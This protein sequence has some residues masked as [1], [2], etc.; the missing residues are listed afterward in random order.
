MK[1]I[2]L[3]KEN[4]LTVSAIATVG[5][6]NISRE[7]CRQ[8]FHFFVDEDI[9][10]ALHGAVPSIMRGFSDETLS[11]G[12]MLQLLRNVSEEY[13]G[14][15]RQTTV[16]TIDHMV[17]NI[18]RKSSTLCTFSNCL[19]TYLAIAPDGHLYTCQR[20][21]G[22]REFSTGKL[23]DHPTPDSI[24]HSKAYTTIYHLY[25]QAREA[26]TRQACKHIGYCNGGCPY[27]SLAAKQHSKAWDGRDPFCQAYR[28]F[29]DELEEKLS[30]EMANELLGKDLPAPLL[31]IAE[32]RKPRYTARANARKILQACQWQK[33]PAWMER[34]QLET[35]FLNITYNCPFRCTH[36]WV[37]A[38]PGRSGEMTIESILKV[39]GEAFALGFRQITITGGEPLFHKDAGTL[40]S[41][42]SAYVQSHRTPHLIL[43]T[44]LAIPLTEAQFTLI[45]QC[46]STVKV[47]IDGNQQQHD[48]R[49]GKGSCRKAIQNILQLLRT[50]PHVRIVLTP[51][52]TVDEMH[53][54]AGA[55]VMQLAKELGGLAVEMRELKPMGRYT[56]REECHEY[57]FSPGILCKPFRPRIKCAMGNQLHIEPGGD[58]YPCYVHINKENY[59]G[60]ISG[61]KALSKAISSDV[62]VRWKAATVDTSP[63]C[64]NCDVRYICGGVCKI[65]Q[66][67]GPEYRYYK[68]LVALARESQ[69]PASAEKVLT[70]C[71]SV[72]Q[73]SDGGLDK[74][75]KC[76]SDL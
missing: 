73:T 11:P 49:R 3:M 47:S 42:L 52:L 50:A 30:A 1:A 39:T 76:P 24:L 75:S 14:A 71:R 27:S 20:F 5:K 57:A 46:F 69:S 58:I 38:G 44:T 35:V 23:Q 64:R 43:Q 51:A 12:E 48:G 31:A 68:Q 56:A 6:Q 54:E 40:L 37:E 34:K 66:D 4:G 15:C 21:C 29:Y 63:R 9:H 17:R 10:F 41:T 8:I 2:R 7:K 45:G 70:K 16:G 74:V 67:C 18:Y 13:F 53:G 22:T 60:N 26:C 36:C 72:R 19:G 62:F 32:N 55:A 33:A 59:L 25:L 28:T 65:K 61:D